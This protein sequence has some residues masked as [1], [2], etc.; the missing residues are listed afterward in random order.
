MLSFLVYLVFL[1]P[2]FSSL[3]PSSLNFFFLLKCLFFWTGPLKMF[4]LS[5]LVF[6]HYKIFTLQTMI[7]FSFF[8]FKNKIM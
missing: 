7:S 4:Y 5:Y 6:L 1:P 8:Y 2:S 3:L